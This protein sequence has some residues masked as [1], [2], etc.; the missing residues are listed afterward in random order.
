LNFL[1]L[2]R[3]PKALD[4]PSIRPLHTMSRRFGVAV[5]QQNKTRWCRFWN[6]F[7]LAYAPWQI[8][9]HL[10][11]SSCGEGFDLVGFVS[12]W[13][14]SMTVVTPTSEVEASN[15]SN[16]NG[17]PCSYGSYSTALKPYYPNFYPQLTINT[18]GR[19]ERHTTMLC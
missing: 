9:R 17:L 15:L 7:V 18:T 6:T 14:H 16:F 11:A 2:N 5:M 1:F 10:V 19:G 4:P 13:G 12:C 3:G 8:M